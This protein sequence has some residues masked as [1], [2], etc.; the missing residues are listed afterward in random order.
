LIYRQG[1]DFLMTARLHPGPA[2][3][4]ERPR[5]L[6]RERLPNLL[7]GYAYHDVGPDGR[8]LVIRS[9]GE[10]PP[11][12]VVIQHFDQELKRLLAKK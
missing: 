12:F 5:Q 9:V 3:T 10:A 2:L 7:D 6:I 1:A 4:V 8:L 11:S